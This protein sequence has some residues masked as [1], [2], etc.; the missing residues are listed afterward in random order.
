MSRNSP[1]FYGWYLVAIC[2]ISMILIYG[3][4]HSFAVFFSPILEEFR[5]S[6]GDIAMMMSLNILIYGF[7]APL[8]GGLADRW[9]P[10]VL[11]P[12]GIIILGVATAG[13]AFATRLWHFYFLFGFLMSIGSAFSGWPIFAPALMN[14][15]T[16][17]RG[18]VLGLGQMG[19]GLSFVYSIFVEFTIRNLGWRHAFLALSFILM[20]SLLPLLFWLFFY[21]PQDKGM[22][23]YGAEDFQPPQPQ[24][25]VERKRER[26]VPP[27]GGGLREVLKTQQ[28]WFLVASYAL[29]WG[30]AG[31]MVM[32]HQVRFL[33]DKGFSS[34]F[35][36]SIFALL[37]IMIFLGQLSAFLSDWLGREKTHSLATCLSIGGLGALLGVNDTSQVWLLYTFAVLFGYGG[38][39]ATPVT[40]A[41][42]ADIFHGRHFGMVGGLLLG[43]MGVGSVLGPWLGGYLFD[44]SGSYKFSFVFSMISLVFSSLFLWFSAPR[45]AVLIDNF[46]KK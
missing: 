17:R 8:A 40:Y 23:A 3:I 25:W 9:R 14:W 41:A 24:P 18:L 29:Y 46:P 15:F 11:I 45:K 4:R 12:I 32:A 38:G 33:Q 35:S 43:G 5:W 20:A 42:S 6:R 44:I 34:V 22:T 7:L 2:I 19:G 10:R 1:I 39:L 30:I 21:R 37:G 31:Y 13:C 27:L 26:S 36:A 16:K 28:L